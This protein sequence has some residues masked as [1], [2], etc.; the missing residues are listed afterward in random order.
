M[1][2]KGDLS[3]LSDFSN[4]SDKSDRLDRSFQIIPDQSPDKREAF[5][6]FYVYKPLSGL[7]K[8]SSS[9]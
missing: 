1:L 8:T 5:G 7:Q 9:G 3:D 2:P 6:L 4:L